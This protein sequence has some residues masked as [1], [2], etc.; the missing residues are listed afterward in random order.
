M[1]LTKHRVRHWKRKNSYSLYTPHATTQTN[2]KCTWSAMCMSKVFQEQSV[3]RISLLLGLNY[4][5]KII[6]LGF[7]CLCVVL[8]VCCQATTLIDLYDPIVAGPL[9]WADWKAAFSDCFCV[10]HMS[11]D[12]WN[13]SHNNNASV[14][15]WLHESTCFCHKAIIIIV[16]DSIYLFTCSFHNLVQTAKSKGPE[17]RHTVM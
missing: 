17:I 16:Y 7:D 10:S 12:P 1:F 4:S 8:F 6:Q 11:W 15:I 9:S 3:I 5:F 2:S 13:T 14:Y